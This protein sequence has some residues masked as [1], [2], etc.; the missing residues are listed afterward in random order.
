MLS[1]SQTIP[2]NMNYRHTFAIKTPLIQSAAILF[3]TAIIVLTFRPGIAFSS[4]TDEIGIIAA[5]NLNMRPE[6]GTDSPPIT[7]L[8]QGAEVKIIK[9]EGIWLKIEY[10]GRVG[11]IKNRERFVHIIPAKPAKE[12]RIGQGKSGDADREIERFER[13]AEDID[14]Q[15]EKR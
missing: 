8:K 3:A 5:Q 6:P 7:V 1:I 13:E 10:N 12:R 9:H 4:A 15:I 11:Y 2:E 14:R